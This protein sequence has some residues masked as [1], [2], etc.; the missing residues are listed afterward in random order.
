MPQTQVGGKKGLAIPKTNKTS[1]VFK[2]RK[3]LKHLIF[4]CQKN[5]F[6]YVNSQQGLGRIPPQ[7]QCISYF[8]N[9]LMFASGTGPRC[10]QGLD[11]QMTFALTY[12]MQCF[13]S[14]ENT[15]IQ[16]HLVEKVDISYLYKCWETELEAQIWCK[17]W[18]KCSKDNFLLSFAFPLMKD[19]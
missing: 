4:F 2:Q 3:I 6:L 12:L 14:Q 7:N 1:A 10:K 15:S 16:M 8:L 19:T 9:F 17:F 11:F 5:L 18:Q 13:C